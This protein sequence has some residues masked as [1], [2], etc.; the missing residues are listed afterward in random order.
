MKQTLKFDG[1]RHLYDTDKAVTLGHKNFGEFGDASGYEETLMKNR[2]GYYFL[3]G[4]GG[5]LSPYNN[6]PSIRPIS[7]TAAMSWLN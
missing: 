5:D 6:A 2:A 4:I 3:V 7:E 1:K